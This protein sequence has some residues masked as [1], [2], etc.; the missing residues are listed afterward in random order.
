MHIK[1]EY[2][3]KMKLKA[4][5]VIGLL[6]I[7]TSV[8]AYAQKEVRVKFRKGGYGTSIQGKT[9]VTYVVH[10]K[11]GQKIDASV[12]S[13]N[14]KWVDMTMYVE[15]P[16]NQFEEENVNKHFIGKAWATGNYKFKIVLEKGA[17]YLFA[18]MVK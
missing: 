15:S 10:I 6:A 12:S 11:K 13:L 17:E 2:Q 16:A 14:R 1:K 3:K 18:I 5:F 7:F 8:S 4:L 9:A